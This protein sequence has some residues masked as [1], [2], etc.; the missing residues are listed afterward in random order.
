MTGR[1]P[2]SL[3]LPTTAILGYSEL[4]LRRLDPDDPLRRHVAEATR[5]AERALDAAA[6]VAP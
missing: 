2:T 4:M 3:F 5:A 6:R 1:D